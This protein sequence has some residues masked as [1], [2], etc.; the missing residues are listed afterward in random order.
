M[1]IYLHLAS[2][3]TEL[4][5]G[6]FLAEGNSVDNLLQKYSKKSIATDFTAYVLEPAKYPATT[7]SDE[8]AELLR[9]GE[10]LVNNYHGTENYMS[11]ILPNFLERLDWLSRKYKDQIT[12]QD[13]TSLGQ[14]ERDLHGIA[15]HINKMSPM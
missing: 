7:A 14:L 5:K 3:A 13:R 9:Q 2:L 15:K 12:D 4:D 8:V 10:R 11:F 1:S 6:G